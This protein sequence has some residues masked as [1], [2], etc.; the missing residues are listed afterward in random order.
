M[1]NQI[2]A[3][4]AA[5]KAPEESSISWTEYF[6]LEAAHPPSRHS[7]TASLVIVLTR[8][9]IPFAKYFIIKIHKSAWVE[10]SPSVKN[11]EAGG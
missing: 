8:E 9:I 4:V 11:E 6:V 2:S 7:S 3:G 10:R 1:C 5:A